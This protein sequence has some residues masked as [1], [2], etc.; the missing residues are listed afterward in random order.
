MHN[1]MYKGATTTA[2]V[3]TVQADNCPGNNCPGWTTAQVGQLSRLDNCPGRTTVQVDNCP[4]VTT[5]PVGQLPR[6]ENCPGWKTAPVQYFFVLFTFFLTLS[7]YCCV[8]TK[9]LMSVTNHT[10]G[11]VYSCQYGSRMFWEMQS[12]IL[13]YVHI[14]F[15]LILPVFFYYCSILRKWLRFMYRLF[16]PS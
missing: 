1:S 7:L 5:A 9:H 11:S 16:M 8:L 10:V 13:N 12:T 15:L 6:F 2:Q 14:S 4:S 3:T